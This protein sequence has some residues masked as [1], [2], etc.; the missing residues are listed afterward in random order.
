[1]VAMTEKFNA[2]SI[3]TLDSVENPI[4]TTGKGINRKVENGFDNPDIWTDRSEKLESNCH[5]RV[6]SLPFKLLETEWCMAVR[7]CHLGWL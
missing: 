2:R 1:M 3:F 5:T 6:F 4:Q 7:K